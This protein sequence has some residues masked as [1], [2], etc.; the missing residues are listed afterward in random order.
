M[1]VIMYFAFKRFNTSNDVGTTSFSLPS[2]LSCVGVSCSHFACNVSMKYTVVSRTNIDI[3]I[4]FLI[5]HYSSR[6]V[7]LNVCETAAR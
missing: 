3:T 1:S 2:V 5:S 4:L 7:F 6:T